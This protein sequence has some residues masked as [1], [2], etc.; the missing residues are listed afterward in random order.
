[1]QNIVATADLGA[2]IDLNAVARSLA[3]KR[4]EYEPEQF[5]GLVYRLDEPKAVVLLFGTGRVVCTGVRTLEDVE[6]AIKRVATELRA[7]GL[8]V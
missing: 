3:Q 1:M 2:R 6:R 7:D 5:P 8:L 4:I